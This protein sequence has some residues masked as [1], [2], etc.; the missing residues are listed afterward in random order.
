[1]TAPP[2]P[3]ADYDTSDHEND[4]IQEQ[5]APTEPIQHDDTIPNPFD[6]K[7]ELPELYPHEMVYATLQENRNCQYAS[8]IA[9][10]IVQHQWETLTDH[11]ADDTI[12]YTRQY[13]V[14]IH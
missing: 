1:M 11:N 2:T 7:I 10:Q 4:G 5:P 8:G 12:Q 13:T 3:E 9:G 6:E 14:S